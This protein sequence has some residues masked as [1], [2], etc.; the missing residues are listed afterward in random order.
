MLKLLFAGLSIASALGFHSAPTAALPVETL[1]M[2]GER[3]TTKVSPPLKPATFSSS[4]LLFLVLL[5]LAP[6]L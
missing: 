1:R 2:I 5:P 3:I 6:I 4:L